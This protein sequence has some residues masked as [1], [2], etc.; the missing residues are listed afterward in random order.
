MEFT[1]NRYPGITSTS[2]IA[3]D[4]WWGSNSQGYI[5]GKILDKSDNDSLVAVDYE[6]YKVSDQSIVDGKL[7]FKVSALDP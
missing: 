3:T 2:I 1:L 7:L 6:P 5:S 4:N